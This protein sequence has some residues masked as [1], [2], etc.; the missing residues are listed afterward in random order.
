M[1]PYQEEENTP[2]EEAKVVSQRVPK[3]KSKQLKVSDLYQPQDD[4]AGGNNELDDIDSVIA[5][6]TQRRA[7]HDEEAASRITGQRSH[8]GAFVKPAHEYDTN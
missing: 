6:Q 5:S 7:Q 8:V 3:N 4:A 1:E 2:D